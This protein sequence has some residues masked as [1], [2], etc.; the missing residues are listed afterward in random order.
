VAREDLQVAVIG[1][2]LEDVPADPY[3]Y[4]KLLRPLLDQTADA[5]R[6]G[7]IAVLRSERTISPQH[8][9]EA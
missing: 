1:N 9:S 2:G 3:E 7:E 6:Q 8:L 5:A 4:A